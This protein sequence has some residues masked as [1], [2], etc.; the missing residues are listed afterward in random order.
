LLFY[1]CFYFFFSFFFFQRDAHYEGNFI[2]RKCEWKIRYKIEK[3][4]RKL[5]KLIKALEKVPRRVCVEFFAE[6][7]APLDE[8]KEMLQGRIIDV[9]LFIYL[10]I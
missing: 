10:I 5:G 6:V 7:T 4:R 2:V 9:H 3:Y 1:C 8:I